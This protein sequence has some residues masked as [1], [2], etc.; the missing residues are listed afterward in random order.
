VNLVLDAGALIGIDRDDRRI[1][2]LIELGRRSGAVLVTSAPV[3]GQVW[4]GTARQARLARLL[5][6]ID[7]RVAGLADARAAGELL[8]ATGTADVVD[9][10]LALSAV[11]GDQLLTSDPNDLRTLVGERGTPMTVVV[12]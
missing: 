9:A 6:M 11:P 2:G 4:R 7:V 12:V 3:V 8:A 5:P 10:L 1:A